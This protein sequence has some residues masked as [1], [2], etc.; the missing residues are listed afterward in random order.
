MNRGAA[1]KN[2]EADSGRCADG[3]AVHRAYISIGSNIGDRAANCERAILAL[4]SAS[5]VRV[6][7][8]SRL[9]LSE[10]VGYADQRW[11]VNAVVKVETTFS[12]FA[13]LGVLQGLER[14]AGRKRSGIRFGPRTLD[15]DI[16]IFDDMI[17]DSDGLEIPHPRMHERRFV[18][19]PLCDIDPRVV[20]PVLKKTARQL[21]DALS[22]DEQKILVREQ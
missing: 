2:F 21:Y 19:G 17:I 8:R 14:D 12:P 18:L 22:E 13:L 3:G 16:V 6:A 20:H 7:A 15:L 9:F 10:P 1:V 4:D 5:G 11:F